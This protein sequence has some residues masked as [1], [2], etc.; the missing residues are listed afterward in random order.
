MAK[1]GGIEGK[2]RMELRIINQGRVLDLR[3]KGYGFAKIAEDLHLG[4]G[5]TYNLHREALIECSHKREE[6]QPVLLEQTIQGFDQLEEVILARGR[7]NL[8]AQRRRADIYME[9]AQGSGG[10]VNGR[11]YQEWQIEVT[12]L[13]NISDETLGLDNDDLDRLLKIRDRRAVYLGVEPA[14]KI[15]VE[16]SFVNKAQEAQNRLRE[17]LGLIPAPQVVAPLEIVQDA[18]VVESAENSEESEDAS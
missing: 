2:G 10:P 4:L 13:T 12:R 6:L 8:E 15:D 5:E 18:E 11:T 14:K 3:K 9:Q 16:H 17:R 7:I 1:S